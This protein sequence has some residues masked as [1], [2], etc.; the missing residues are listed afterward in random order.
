MK[1]IQNVHTAPITVNARDGHGK[2]LFTKQFL[3]ARSDKFT[4][5]LEVTGYT[6][7]TEE[8]YDALKT[9]SKTFTVYKDKH[10]L[11]V[12]HEDLPAEAKTPHQALVDARKEAR[13][14]ADE[15]EVLKAE[16]EKLKASLF[17]AE[18]KYKELSAASTDAEKV[19]AFTDKIAELEAAVVE[20]SKDA[21]SA[22]TE[23]DA[24]TDTG[25]GKGKSKGKDFE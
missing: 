18:T 21:V 7:L 6:A 11:L 23:V 20:L 5:K 12:E 22:D 13:K 10:H 19:K 4:G 14:H 1:Y 15:I 8:E 17:D 3:P 25:K 2:V 16:N 24:D 9:S